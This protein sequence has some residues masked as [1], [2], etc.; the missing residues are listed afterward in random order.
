MRWLPEMLENIHMLQ[1]KKKKN[2][3]KTKHFK[4]MHNKK[5]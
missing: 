4:F 3:T 2:P 1:K 5:I